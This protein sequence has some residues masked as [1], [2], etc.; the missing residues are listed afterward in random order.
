MGRTALVTGAN[1]FVGRILAA[2]LESEGWDV[3]ATVV[4]GA[5][6]SQS[7]FECDIA[8]DEQV[9]ALIRWAG[10]VT[11]V[12][13]LA[14]VTFIPASQAHPSRTM[15][16]NLNGTIR[17][18]EA[19]RKHT[20]GARFLYV[21]S[22]AVYGVPRTIPIREDHP[23]QPNEPYAI[24]KAAADAYCDYLFRNYGMDVIRL[25]PFN[26][27][28]PGQSPQFV[29]S[30]FARQIAQIDSGSADPLLRVGNL[31]VAR[32]FLH[33]DDVV[34]AYSSIAARG[35]SGE[36]YNVC[37]GESWTIGAAME[38]FQSLSHREF[39]VEVDPERLRRVDI[40]DVRGSREK[41]TAQTGWE[42]KASFESLLQDL[43]DYWRG[44]ITANPS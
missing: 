43:L 40:P 42:P 17:L 39:T 41:L 4:P 7:A 10:P 36:V 31:D 32:D 13:H 22:A 38:T 8:D 9:D 21:G 23:L 34:R 29:L 26:H 1:G 12:F 14:A 28:G 30:N 44:Q 27:S 15:D 24:S 2:H 35:E 37:S 33:V 3:R 16:I 19:V 20:P 25:R 6:D 5:G 18:A 11:H